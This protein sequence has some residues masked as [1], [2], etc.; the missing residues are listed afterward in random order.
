MTGDLDARGTGPAS[1]APPPPLPAA[2]R[3]A[4][5]ARYVLVFVTAVLLVDAVFGEKGVLA[6]VQ[7][8][9]EFSA[10]ERAL[11]TARE[12]NAALRDQ[13][14][15][16]REDP[17]AIEALARGQLGLIKPGEKL[18]IVKDVAKK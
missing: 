6:L 14:R 7:A 9:R 5:L 17:A 8:R 18:F 3:W 16:L 13:A 15:R 4:G 2:R 12:E 11:E 10:V 1:A